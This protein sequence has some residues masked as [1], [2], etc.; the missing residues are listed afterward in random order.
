MQNR[1]M[2][3]GASLTF[4]DAILRHKGEASEVTERFRRLSH[5]QK[6]DLFQFLRSL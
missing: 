4:L 5:A 1:L 2:H 3:D 6:E